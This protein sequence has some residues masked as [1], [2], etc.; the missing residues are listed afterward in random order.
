MLNFGLDIVLAKSQPRYRFAVISVVVMI[1]HKSQELNM[2]KMVLVA[3]LAAPL[4]LS[5]CI[6]SIDGEG[7]DSYHTD[8]QDREHKNRN[9]LNKLS[10]DMTYVQV[11]ERMGVADFNE[12]HKRGEDTYQVLF[13]RTQRRA[14]DG[15][16]SKDECTQI[17]FKNGVLVGWGDKAYGAI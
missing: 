15:V 11:T 8:W 16:T 1:K 2:K 17:V 3:A 4:L 12:L 5:G 9:N 6:I 14:E 7:Y 13:Y 10:A